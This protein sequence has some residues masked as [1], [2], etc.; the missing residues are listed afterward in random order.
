VRGLAEVE[1]TTVFGE[2]FP[3]VPLIAAVS[4]VNEFVNDSDK[5][6]APTRAI[7]EQRLIAVN[8]LK[9][10]PGDDPKKSPQ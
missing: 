1:V 5:P 8:F 2:I 9:S 3:S 10:R 7:E 6:D 4:S